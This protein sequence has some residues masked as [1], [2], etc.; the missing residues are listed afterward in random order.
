MISWCQ[1]WSKLP[2]FY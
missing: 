2:V 1:G